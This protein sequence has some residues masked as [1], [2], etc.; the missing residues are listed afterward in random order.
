[1]K[2]RSKNLLI[3]GG[4]G[5]I[6]SNFID[7]FF[8]NFIGSKVYNLDLLTYA[9]NLNNTSKFCKNPD[10]KFIEGDICDSKLLDEIFFEYKIDGVINF[11]AESH[12]DKSIVNPES[13]VRTNVNGVFTLLEAAYKFWF[14]SPFKS[15]PNLNHARFH[16]ISTDEIYGSI[17]SGSFFEDSKYSPNSPYSASKASADMLVRSYNKTFGLNTTIS[18]CTN[19][20]GPNQ[21]IEKFIPKIIY[22]LLNNKEIPVYGDGKNTRDWI[23]VKDHC[24]AVALIYNKSKNGNTYNVCGD[25]E[26]TNLEIIDM[27]HRLTSNY[28]DVSKKIIFIDD[29]FGHDRRY[30]IN[31][32]KIINE[33]DWEN[34]HDFIS[35]LDKY[36]KTLINE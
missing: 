28:R 34:N 2:F 31:Q 6:G 10:Y 14:K 27:I 32:S 17:N 35:Q 18:V 25:N 13:F 7:Y 21:N 26:F 19:N 1:M 36:I 5:F 11:A 23:Y 3:T 16:Q 33:L 30:S 15:K 24:K 12:V 22:S 20:F 29:R 4:A 9:G 8:K